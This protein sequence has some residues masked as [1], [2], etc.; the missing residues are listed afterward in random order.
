MQIYEEFAILLDSVLYK[1]PSSAFN[2]T[3]T[4][5]DKCFIN[6]RGS[7]RWCLNIPS[8]LC[9]T[10]QDYSLLRIYDTLQTVR[11][12]PPYRMG[13]RRVSVHNGLM[14]PLDAFVAREKCILSYGHVA[15]L[16]FMHNDYL[17]LNSVNLLHPFVLIVV[18]TSRVSTCVLYVFALKDHSLS[19]LI[20][21]PVP[22]QFCTEINREIPHTYTALIRWV[23]PY[24]AL[25][26][27]L[28]VPL[29]GF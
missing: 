2:S 14:S 12:W 16:D 8:I 15:M 6:T 28:M 24:L 23:N 9:T 20:R 29:E 1:A 21:F 22:Y 27:L 26:E 7:E 10:T 19:Y 18:G 5:R 25:S 4:V 13:K 17:D 11:P 3:S